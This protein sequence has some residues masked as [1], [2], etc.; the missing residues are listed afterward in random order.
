MWW[1][2]EQ[3]HDNRNVLAWWFTK[4]TG[5][6]AHY[7]RVLGYRDLK[8][9]KVSSLPQWVML[10]STVKINDLLWIKKPSVSFTFPSTGIRVFNISNQCSND[11]RPCLSLYFLTLTVQQTKYAWGSNCLK[12]FAEAHGLRNSKFPKTNNEAQYNLLWKWFAFFFYK[13]TISTI[14]FILFCVTKAIPKVMN[15]NQ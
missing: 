5:G 10:G 6:K 4:D 15:K 14:I 3:S 9:D 1:G 7:R 2:D 11:K 13:V 12:F 8:N